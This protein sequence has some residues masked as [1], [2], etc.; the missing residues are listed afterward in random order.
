MDQKK[1]VGFLSFW[2]VNTVVLLVA[3]VIFSGNVVLGNSRVSTPMAAIISGLIITGLTSLVQPLVAK[4]GFRVKGNLMGGV[5]LVA[6][7]VFV[8]IIKHFALTLGLGVATINF[9]PYVIPVGIL[10][11]AGQWAVA[12]ATGQMNKK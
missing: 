6:N 5:Y 7:I 9:I 10:L 1:L 3:S 12:K 8:W 11:T 4:S 2:V